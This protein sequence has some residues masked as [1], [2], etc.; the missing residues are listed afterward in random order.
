MSAAV[1]ILGCVCGQ[2]PPAVAIPPDQFLALV[3][4]EAVP[5]WSSYTA[6]TQACELRCRSE[7]RHFKSNGE[8]IPDHP[9]NK[10]IEDILLLLDN[11]GSHRKSITRTVQN[12]KKNIYTID[13]FNSKYSFELRGFAAD[14]MILR[15]ITSPITPEDVV[16]RSV[17]ATVAARCY[18]WATLGKPLPELWADSNCTLEPVRRNGRGHY[19]VPF[20]MRK[21]RA[22]VRYEVELNPDQGWRI[23]AS[24]SIIPDRL[25]RTEEMSYETPGFSVP[26]PNRYVYTETDLK[27]GQRLQ[28]VTSV[29]YFEGK[30]KK[31]EKEFTLS[32]FGMPEPVGVTWE[33]PTPRYVWFLLGAG[34][35]AALMIGFRYLARRRATK[36][37]APT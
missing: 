29:T 2:T 36:S 26:I 19:L 14:Q 32:A 4:R 17:R 12:D 33:K 20:L 5:K 34:G 30:P 7:Y 15:N 18:G 9:G 35:F 1:L 11:Y 21:D 37:P 28:A 6:M 10:S 27:T 23:E 3:H 24:K 25:D 8:S 13:C 16:S 22:A 31:A